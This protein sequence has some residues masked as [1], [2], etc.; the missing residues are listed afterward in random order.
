MRLAW[1]LLVPGED[2]PRPSR[3][4][5]CKLDAR[6]K[7][8]SP[9]WRRHEQEL[10]TKAHRTAARLFREAED[11]RAAVDGIRLWHADDTIASYVAEVVLPSIERNPKLR[12]NTRRKYAGELATLTRLTGDRMSIAKFLEYRTLEALLVSCA[13]DHGTA[14]ARQL[15]SVISGHVL[16]ELRH[17]K[18]CPVVPPVDEVVL[19]EVNRGTQRRITSG[20]TGQVL[21]VSPADRARLVRCLLAEDPEEHVTRGHGMTPEE[22]TYRRRALVDLTLLQATCGLRVSECLT[23]TVGNVRQGGNVALVEV[24]DERSKTGNGRLVPLFD[25]TFGEAV[26]ERLL[27][28]CQGLADGAPVFGACKNPSKPWG[29]DNARR[30]LRTFYDELAKT[31]GIPVLRQRATHIWRA[32]LNAEYRDAMPQVM[33][34]DLFGHTTQT[35]SSYYTSKWTLGDVLDAARSAKGDTGNDPYGIRLTA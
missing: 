21:V 8:G 13:K 7:K 31:L 28:R 29:A 11:A 18:L 35:N 14:T 27:R 3:Y 2:K 6:C 26:S 25:P 30:A 4:T 23:L 33:R 32:S 16:A 22:A 9:T 17:D 24:T 10:K 20:T 5:S 15:Q 1:T 34:A 12:P 19:P